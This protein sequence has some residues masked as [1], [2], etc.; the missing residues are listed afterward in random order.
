[1]VHKKIDTRMSRQKATTRLQKLV[2]WE[3]RL[4]SATS[5]TLH[6]PD[7]LFH[8]CPEK[9]AT[10]FLTL[11]TWASNCRRSECKATASMARAGP[12]T[13]DYDATKNFGMNRTWCTYPQL[14]VLK[15][16]I[17]Q[18][19]LMFAPK[20]CKY[21]NQ[22]WP[23]TSSISN[24]CRSLSLCLSLFLSLSLSLCLSLPRPLYGFLWFSL[25]FSVFLCLCVSVSLCLSLSVS[26]CLCL[27]LPL[28]L[29]LFFSVS[30][31][32][33]PSV[34]SSVLP[35]VGWPLCLYLC[36]SLCLSFSLSLCLSL[37][38]SLSLC[39]PLSLSQ[40]SHSSL[41]ALSLSSLS[42][43]SLSLLPHSALSLSLSLHLFLRPSFRRLA[44]LSLSL[45]LS[46]SLCLSFSLSVS[47]YLSLSISLT[48]LSQLSLSPPSLSDSL[49]L[50][51]SLSL[52]FFNHGFACS[53]IIFVSY[54]NR[55]YRSCYPTTSFAPHKSASKFF[56]SHLQ[57]PSYGCARSIWIYTIQIIIC[58][59]IYMC[60]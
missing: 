4:G 29:S 5:A 39:L 10:G 6:L 20:K 44:A 2:S 30:V 49:T 26:V 52:P 8:N 17:P 54:L 3:S 21:S 53:S 11:G 25:S 13:G 22:K 15:R 32:V 14:M 9:S 18:I 56:Q 36:L 1:M 50:S 45:S 27:S 37:S 16:K 19:N 57:F 47:V 60:E 43:L 12:A 31:S 41:S 55:E 58:I 24:P 7:C 48:A 42:A 38:V 28:S 46:L 23:D 35:S 34:C 33:S 40:L 59:Y 51:L